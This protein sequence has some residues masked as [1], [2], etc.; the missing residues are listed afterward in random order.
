[1]QRILTEKKKETMDFIVHNCN[2]VEEFV[3]NLNSIGV[4]EYLGFF[5]VELK[6]NC[7]L[8]LE[9]TRKMLIDVITYL[10]KK[11]DYI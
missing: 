5:G 8:E 2:S 4:V 7:G 9:V 6:T 11:G 1:M 3:L 10:M